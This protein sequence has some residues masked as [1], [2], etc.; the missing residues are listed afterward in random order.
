MRRRKLGTFEELMKLD[1]KKFKFHSVLSPEE[2]RKLIEE[3]KRPIT[4]E[5]SHEMA[6]EDFKD[7][8]RSRTRSIKDLQ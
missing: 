3:S 5:E 4:L 1:P 8:K 6:R 2:S 7:L